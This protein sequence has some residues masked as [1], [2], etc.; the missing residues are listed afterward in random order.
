M[1]RWPTAS[2]VTQTRRVNGGVRARYTW[3]QNQQSSKQEGSAGVCMPS[4][5]ARDL[6]HAN[7]CWRAA[8]LP[9]HSTIDANKLTLEDWL[10][11]LA[12]KL[13]QFAAREQRGELYSALPFSSGACVHTETHLWSTS[14]I[15]EQIPILAT[16]VPNTSTR[17]AQKKS[18]PSKAPQHACTLR[19]TLPINQCMAQERHAHPSHYALPMFKPIARAIPAQLA[20]AHACGWPA[21]HAGGPC[22]SPRQGCLPGWTPSGALHCACGS[23]LGPPQSPADMCVCVCVK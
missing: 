6:S 23:H 15:W 18:T 4:V 9:K 21:P 2:A 14:C 5:L 11:L 19:T 10:R 13:H 7:K 8:A 20:A 16:A 12:E 22:K 3:P 1:S 17:V